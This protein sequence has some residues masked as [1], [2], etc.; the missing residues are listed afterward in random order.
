[1][2]GFA[3]EGQSNQNCGILFKN[4]FTIGGGTVVGKGTN[5]AYNKAPAIDSEFTKA[6]IWY[7]EAEDIA[8]ADGPKSIGEIETQY[9]QNYVRVSIADI[10][11][12]NSAGTSGIFEV[13]PP[14]TG[15]YSSLWLWVTLAFVSGGML[16]ERTLDE[17]KRE[18]KRKDK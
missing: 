1:M 14:K 5:G 7:G 4:T 10:G 16:L 11:T 9:T 13:E 17:C 12:E 18:R 3:G 8:D 15:D 2:K 6:G